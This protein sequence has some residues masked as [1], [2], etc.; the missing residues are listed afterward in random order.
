MRVPATA[1]ILFLAIALAVSLG[2]AQEGGDKP[3][4]GEETEAPVPEGEGTGE[5]DAEPVTPEGEKPAPESAG[6]GTPESA[7]E[8]TKPG[9]GEAKPA[10][11]ETPPVAPESKPGETAAPGGKT[12]E[13][14]PEKA[15]PE[16]G[17]G[18]TGEAAAPAPSTGKKTPRKNDLMRIQIGEGGS[19]K[20]QFTD[21]SVFNAEPESRLEI[22]RESRE[23]KFKVALDLSRGKIRGVS[24]RGY[25]CLGLCG[26]RIFGLDTEEEISVD[27]DG[28]GSIV[29]KGKGK[30]GLCWKET[31]LLELRGGQGISITPEDTIEALASNPG[32]VGVIRGGKVDL[33]KPGAKLTYTPG[34]KSTD[35]PA[36]CQKLANP[37][38]LKDWFTLDTGEDGGIEFLLRD[39]GRIATVED[40]QAQF[41]IFFMEKS[42]RETKMNV[43]AGEY[44]FDLGPDLV[45]VD[46][47]KV[48]NLSGRNSVFL[49]STGLAGANRHRFETL[50]GE[51]LRAITHKDLLKDFEITI[52][53]DAKSAVEAFV[54]EA[55]QDVVFEV[56]PE[57]ERPVLFLVSPAGKKRAR[58]KKL[59]APAGSRLRFARKGK[60][61]T[62]RIPRPEGEFAATIP[63][64]GGVPAPG[65]SALQDHGDL[66]EI[67]NVSPG[68]P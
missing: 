53:A 25:I 33:L 22:R 66:I 27:E 36:I 12:G 35:L 38:F 8:G 19:A 49:V 67:E 26:L 31:M 39:G 46:I 52:Q 32:D 40:T 65:D 2:L 62:V 24:K 15:A 59:L 47:P 30:L 17:T 41:E 20:F 1:L 13:K 57:T 45:T 16:S 34:P 37:D 14:Q 60:V 6:E 21:G 3:S 56:S 11:G 23:E 42:P 7:D 9:E 48:M 29:N 5:P 55:S 43:S 50:G 58:V 68:N 61:V 44:S 4:G 54:D 28:V 63:L 10:T 18:K 64:A 51:R